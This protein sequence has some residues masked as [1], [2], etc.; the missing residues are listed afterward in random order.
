MVLGQE[1]I[2]MNKKEFGQLPHTIYK[3]KLK[4]IVDLIY[5]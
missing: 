1:D 5:N 4:K 3:N 2:H